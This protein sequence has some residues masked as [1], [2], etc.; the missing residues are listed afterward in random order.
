[1][2]GRTEKDHVDREPGNQISLPLY[3]LEASQIEANTK[4]FLTILMLSF[5]LRCY[6]ACDIFP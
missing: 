2:F 3:E 4:L 5:H 1:M 6:R